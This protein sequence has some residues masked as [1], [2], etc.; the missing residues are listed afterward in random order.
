MRSH[1]L[2]G[3]W[4]SRG[5]TMDGRGRTG[6]EAGKV[7]AYQPDI[8]TVGLDV[9]FCGVNPALTAVTDGHNFSNPT[10]AFGGPS[11][12]P[13]SPIGFSSHPRSGSCSNMAAA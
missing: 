4:D 2:D 7:G 6:R 5:G 3:V 9:V 13:A 12:W 10:I 8:L 11:N 1:F